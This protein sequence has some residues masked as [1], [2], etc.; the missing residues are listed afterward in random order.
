MFILL[1]RIF[2]CTFTLSIENLIKEPI[3]G[4]GFF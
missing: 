2:N 1:A 3:I 4:D